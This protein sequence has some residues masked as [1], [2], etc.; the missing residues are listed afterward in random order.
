VYSFGAR[1]TASTRR[2]IDT[3]Q[4]LYLD[5]MSKG[6]LHER[7]FGAAV[8]PEADLVLYAD[9]FRAQEPDQARLY[10]AQQLLATKRGFPAALP[11]AFERGR[12][13][14]LRV[15]A[16]HGITLHMGP[17]GYLAFMA[18]DSRA[19]LEEHGLLT[20]PVSVFGSESTGAVASAL[21]SGPSR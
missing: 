14:L 15:A 12:T 10:V 19:L 17:S 2:L 9:I 13:H 7:V 6:W 21:L 8:V 16:E 4:V 18:I 20:I 3:G 1:L 5:S 11:A